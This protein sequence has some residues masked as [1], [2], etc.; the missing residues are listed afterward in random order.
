MTYQNHTA[1]LIDAE[2]TPIGKLTTFL[3]KWRPFDRE[4]TLKRAYGNWSNPCLKNWGHLLRT[5]AVRPVQLFDCA[6][7]KNAADI[8]LVAD[9]MEL[10]HTGQYDT[11]IIMAS[12]SDYTPLVMKLR[13]AGV[14]IMG[15]GKDDA[16]DAYRNACTN[17]VCLHNIY[18]EDP[19]SLQAM[20]E[21][22][23][24]GEEDDELPAESCGLI[25]DDL[26]REN[27]DDLDTSFL[28]D[29]DETLGEAETIEEDPFADLEEIPILEEKPDFS[30]PVAKDSIWDS[31][32]EE[33]EKEEAKAETEEIVWDSLDDLLN[34]PDEPVETAEAVKEEIVW[35]TLGE[36]DGDVDFDWPPISGIGKD[37]KLIWETISTV[38]ENGEVIWDTLDDFPKIISQEELTARMHSV[39]K[40][41]HVAYDCCKDEQG[42]AL[43]SS[44]G[45]F[46]K[47]IRPEFDYRDYG[48]KQLHELLLAYPNK[49]QLVKYPKKVLA[50][51]CCA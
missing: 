47:E 6:T 39:H 12:D 20:L 32:F 45:N 34:E 26:L 35:D 33:T 29:E 48:F 18:S 3:E 51:R 41:L 15:V 17:Y 28:F 24:F 2:N 14:R 37:G 16:S 22:F 19:D 42:Y 1:L 21:R 43:L 7:G 49:Y 8:A 30:A 40:L 9:A 25:E 11:F 31:L 4:I 36:D 50:F 46:I 44:I 27:E 13:E 10:L 23:D 5:H 38:D